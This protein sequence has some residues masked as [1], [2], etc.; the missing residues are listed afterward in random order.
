MYEEWSQLPYAA[1]SAS[2]F[3]N[4]VI[5]NQEKMEIETLIGTKQM[6]R[7]LDILIQSLN[8]KVTTKYMGLLKAM[9]KNDDVT[10]CSKVRELGKCIKLTTKYSYI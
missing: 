5:T 6:E 1:M 2:L 10:L 8:C 9:E 7:V 4:H 3:A